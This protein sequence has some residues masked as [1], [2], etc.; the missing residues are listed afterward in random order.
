MISR[1]INLILWVILTQMENFV[2]QTR[3]RFHSFNCIAIRLIRQYL[4]K[5]EDITKAVLRYEFVSY[6]L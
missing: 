3:V 6:E 4:R 1:W 5:R 2:C